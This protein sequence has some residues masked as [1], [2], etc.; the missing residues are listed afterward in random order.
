M[1][2]LFAEPAVIRWITLH[3]PDY[4]NAVIVSPDAG[5]KNFAF[6]ERSET[7]FLVDLLGAKRYIEMIFLFFISL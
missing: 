7:I 2:N 4:K 3:I 5:G 1:D 6:F